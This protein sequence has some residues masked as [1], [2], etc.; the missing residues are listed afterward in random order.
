MKKILAVC[1][2]AVLAAGLALLGA[3]LPASAD[4]KI[5]P[6]GNGWVKTDA[7]GPE[8]FEVNFDA[9]D[10]F[11]I[12]GTC[13]K[14]ADGIVR[15]DD[16]APPV[17][18]VTVA[19]PAVNQN[20][21]PQA[22][23]HYSVLLIAKVVVPVKPEPTTTR[24]P[25]EA[26]DCEARVVNLSTKVT[27][28]DW[29]LV[30]NVWVAAEPTITTEA[31]EPRAATEAECP[32]TPPVVTPLACTPVGDWYTEGDDN[33]PVATP[34]GLTFTGG[35][36]KATGLRVP[37]SG[38]LQGWAPVSYNATGAT[39]K[40][41]FRIV[42]DSTPNNGDGHPYSSLTVTSGSPVTL[43]SI[44]YSNKLG[45]SFTL[46]EIANLYPH[47]VITSVGFHLDSAAAADDTVTLTSATGP[48]ATR[49]FTYVEVPEKPEPIV[50]TEVTEDTDCEADV[51][52][53][54]TTTTTVD[55]VLVD[56][57][58]VRGEPVVTT[59]AED[60]AAT[61]EDC[62]VVVPPTEE[63]PVVTPP[64]VT[65]PAAPASVAPA[66]VVTAPV[67]AEL[68]ETGV[69]GGEWALFAVASLLIGLS[70]YFTA[71]HFGRKKFDKQA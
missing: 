31:G 50:T 21:K 34:A 8:V 46:A 12:G 5:C 32:T 7:T 3:S 28:T 63:S 16:I 55:W 42:I 56:N 27:T 18:T 58:W 39:D 54:T 15:T 68:A 61:A 1:T 60:R 64:V 65:P 19:S 40:F 33:A 37:A 25:S 67:E 2:T 11:L 62:P 26:L 35:T 14:A 44:A 22:V 49:D 20:N 71:V 43:D 9:P 69:S 66:A 4:E 59:V 41:Y 23:S 13:V 53:K 47:A 17:E 51:V 36:G 70:L 45:G 57:V 10:G 30:D 38:N 24:E 48:C 52:T 6:E 29:T